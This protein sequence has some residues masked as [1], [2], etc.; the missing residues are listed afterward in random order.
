MKLSRNHNRQSTVCVRELATSKTRPRHVVQSRAGKRVFYL[1]PLRPFVFLPAPRPPLPPL[2]EPLPWTRSGGA[3]GIWPRGACAIPGG[4]YK[5][6]AENLL[7]P[8]ASGLRSGAAPDDCPWLCLNTEHQN[9]IETIRTQ[10]R[11]CTESNS[12]YDDSACEGCV[13]PMIVIACTCTSCFL[14]LLCALARA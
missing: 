7:G 1:C 3:A 2:P 9:N 13:L 10:H 5:G 11:P 6:C 14:L 4:W 8:P 12:A